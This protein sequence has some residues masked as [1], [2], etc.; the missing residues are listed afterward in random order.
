MRAILRRSA[1]CFIGDR[2][3]RLVFAFAHRRDRKSEIGASKTE[4]QSVAISDRISKQ[5]AFRI[6]TVLAAASGRRQIANPVVPMGIGCFMNIRLHNVPST[7]DAHEHRLAP[8]FS[9]TKSSAAQVARGNRRIAQRRSSCREMFTVSAD[10]T[11]STCGCRAVA[12]EVW[13]LRE[14]HCFLSKAGYDL[15]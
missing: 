9:G 15:T 6:S 8:A 11:T 7:A 1:C 5:I 3:R 4:E 10:C 14:K 2:L 13:N 12:S